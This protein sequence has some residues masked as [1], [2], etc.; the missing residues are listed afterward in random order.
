M[1]P[2]VFLSH[3]A[4]YLPIVDCPA[5][6]FLRRLGDNFER[7]EAILII[8]A[9]W[10]TSHPTV[11]A[12]A[13]NPTIHDFRGFPAEL[14][15]L[16]YPAPGS[17]DLAQRITGLLGQ[18]GFSTNTDTA[19]G[20]DHGAWVPLILA[21]P[22]ADI[23]VVQ[24]SIQSALGPSHHFKLGRAIG[25]LRATGV[26]IVGSGSYTHN[27]SEFFHA[28]ARKVEE[29]EW[30]SAFSDWFDKALMENRTDDL[31]NYRQIAPDAE[32]NHPTEEHLLPIF[33]ALGASGDPHETLRLH[34][35]SD[36]GILRLDAYAFQ[37]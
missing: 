15:A 18:A 33:V 28:D 21:Y 37:S 7:P 4:P 25:T 11:N 1:L 6:D 35:S 27:L 12:V 34:S 30:V 13:V 5:R 17:P 32:R 16:R 8:S 36:R 3:G 23:P 2:T 29:P 9:H 20:L 14:H 24:L 22:K 31:L 19:R 26:L 10:E